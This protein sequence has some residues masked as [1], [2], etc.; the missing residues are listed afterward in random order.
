[1]GTVYRA[2][3]SGTTLVVALKQVRVRR[4]GEE[5]TRQFRKEI[6]SVAEELKKR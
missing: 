4:Q 2:R 6:E 5:A 3:L 1:M